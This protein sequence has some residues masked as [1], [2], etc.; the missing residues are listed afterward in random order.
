MSVAM[1]IF[2]DTLANG[3]GEMSKLWH[4][5]RRAGLEVMNWKGTK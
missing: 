3:R 2:L 5:M 1:E 4:N